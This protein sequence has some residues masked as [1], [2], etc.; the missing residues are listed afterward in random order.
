LAVS[1]SFLQQMWFLILL[2]MIGLLSLRSNVLTT[3]MR[4]SS[5]FAPIESKLPEASKILNDEVKVAELVHKLLKNATS[6]QHVPEADRAKQF[7]EYH[8]PTYEYINTLLQRHRT[9]DTTKPLFIGVSA[10]QVK[11][12][13]HHCELQCAHPFQF[14]FDLIIAGL[15]QDHPHKCDLRL[16]PLGGQALHCHVVG[17]FLSARGAAGTA[18]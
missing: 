18:R 8:I 7:A 5:V 12:H 6:M 13:K 15:W 10:P 16:V 3:A 4:S 9:K 1:R 17:R 11:H 2:G 14:W